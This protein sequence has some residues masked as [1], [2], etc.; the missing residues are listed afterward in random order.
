MREKLTETNCVVCLFSVSTFLFSVRAIF[1]YAA[2]LG[3]D[4]SKTMK[5]SY[6]LIKKSDI[7]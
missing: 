6:N 1:E 4:I 3:L 7:L 2:R 5:F